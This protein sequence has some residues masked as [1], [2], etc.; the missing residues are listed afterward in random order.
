M[1]AALARHDAI[2]RAE[3]ERS[4]G[5]IAKFMGDGVLAVFDHPADAVTAAVNAQVTLAAEQWPGTPLRVRMGI[6]TGE[7]R[8]RGG[9]VFGPNVNLAAR[10]Q[11]AAHG[12]QILL[13]ANTEL[14]VRDS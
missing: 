1:D 3:I 7:V 12:G 13:S 4:H 11:G 14:L 2:L 5:T 6:H 10:I 9:D 8:A